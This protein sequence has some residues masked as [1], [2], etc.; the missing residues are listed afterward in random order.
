MRKFLH[1]ISILAMIAFPLAAAL[2]VFFDKEPEPEVYAPEESVKCAIELGNYENT[3]RG[4]VNGY[5]FELLK[6]FAQEYGVKADVVISRTGEQYLDSLAA[7]IV[8]IVVVPGKDISK[9]E[10]DLAYSKPVDNLT[11]WAVRS[12]EKTMQEALWKWLD[13]YAES[14]E[15]ELLHK[16]YFDAFNNPL[17]VAELGRKRDHLGPYDGIIRQ[18][19]DSLGWDWR[20]L[21]AV[22]YQES[23]FHIEAQSKK[24]ATGLMQLLPST[25][26][27]HRHE[28]DDLLD[29][30]QN[31]KTGVRYLRRL[32]RMFR[33]RADGQE[34]VQKFALAAYNAGEGH[35][36]DAINF[37]NWVKMKS[38]TWEDL[39][40][41]FPTM[42]ED[43]ILQIDTVKLGKFIA[44]QTVDYVTGVYDLYDA[45]CAIC[46]EK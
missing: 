38:D 31:I 34:N 11:L 41:I 16:A 13:D 42:A 23:K 8:D 5:N 39:S 46:P 6:M 44:G 19:A 29:P 18:Y 3:V 43:F 33:S 2:H 9:E 15:H 7:G 20:L 36:I 40:A 24:G 30:E 37:A 12:E 45:F 35:I 21:A 1:C 17:R 14:E 26:E 25:A 27:H 28:G 10:L 4:Y 22:I 32:Q